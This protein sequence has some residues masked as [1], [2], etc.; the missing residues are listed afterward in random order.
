MNPSKVVIQDSVW[1]VYIGDE[2]DEVGTRSGTCHG[3][4][5]WLHVV[6]VIVYI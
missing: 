5:G 2:G 4:W 6:T 1:A 3:G